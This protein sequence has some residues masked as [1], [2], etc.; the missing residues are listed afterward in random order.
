[1]ATGWM[2]GVRFQTGV[3]IY[4]FSAKFTP[5]LGC[6]QS[7]TPYC[8]YTDW[9]HI[10]MLML[11]GNTVSTLLRHIPVTDQQMTYS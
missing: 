9:F 3:R 1:M 2:P 11:S 10:V 6:T 4:F 8:P 5:V 7:S